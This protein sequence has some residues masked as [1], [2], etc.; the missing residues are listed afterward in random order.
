M[1]KFDW[2][3]CSFWNGNHPLQEVEAKLSDLLVPP[4]DEADTEHGEA[5]RIISRFYYDLYNN[6]MC[7]VHPGSY[8]MDLIPTLRAYNKKNIGSVA[9]NEFL[10]L[11]RKFNR[12]DGYISDSG[13]QSLGPVMESAFEDVVIH[14]AEIEGLELPTVKTWE[15]WAEVGTGKKDRYTHD[16][17]DIFSYTESSVCGEVVEFSGVV[18]KAFPDAIRAVLYLDNLVLDLVDKDDMVV[19]D[20]HLDSNVKLSG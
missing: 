3:V 2:T 18:C 10:N 13:E 5:L 8:L 4:R 7:N 20:L 1:T 6:G 16:L 12:N 11:T 15:T 9:V 19:F 17:H 14:C